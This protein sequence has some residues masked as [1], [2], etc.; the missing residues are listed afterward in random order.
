MFVEGAINE[1]VIRGRACVSGQ[2]Y[3]F[4]SLLTLLTAVF[5][6]FIEIDPC[7]EA[8]FNTNRP[9]AA[10]RPTTSGLYLLSLAL[11]DL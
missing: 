10:L 5:A 1:D 6:S 7:F 4:F 9:V 3:F 11:T 8:G 2:G